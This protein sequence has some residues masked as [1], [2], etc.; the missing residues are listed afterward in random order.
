MRGLTELEWSIL[1]QCQKEGYTYVALNDGHARAFDTDEKPYLKG[2]MYRI[3]TE[4]YNPQYDE[5][6]SL[7]IFGEVL[8]VPGLF[9]DTGYHVIDLNKLT[10]QG[11]LF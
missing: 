4:Q 7:T 10:V 8:F 5:S 9:K 3:E 2:G 1:E 6:Y 11:K